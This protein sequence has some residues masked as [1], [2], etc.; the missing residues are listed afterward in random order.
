MNFEPG[1]PVTNCTQQIALFPSCKRRI[2]ETGIDGGDIS[3]D[4]GAL[5]LRQADRYLGLCESVAAALDD[6]RR[7]ASCRHDNLSLLRQ[8]VFG[9]ALGYE[10]LNDPIQ[11][12]ETI[13]RFRLH[14]GE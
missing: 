5:L 2:I 13:W 7:S 14:W 12:C 3:S 9:L 8:R 1:M 10:D 11:H 4:G 6:P